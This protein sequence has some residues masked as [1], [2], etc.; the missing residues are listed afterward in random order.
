MPKVFVL[1]S[2]LFMFSLQAC[3]QVETP[4]SNDLSAF[5]QESHF[6]TAE[7][8]DAAF[9]AGL[10]G[11]TRAEALTPLVFDP[12]GHLLTVNEFNSGLQEDDSDWQTYFTDLSTFRKV[13]ADLVAAGKQSEKRLTD[14]TEESAV[15]LPANETATVFIYVYDPYERR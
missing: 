11:V 1:V 4:V 5:R 13:M 14:A 15:Q 8:S 3:R 6:W 9:Q 10:V 2:V 12:T 7:E